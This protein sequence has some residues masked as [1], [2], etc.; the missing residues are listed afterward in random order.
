M[1]YRVALVVPEALM[2]L[3]GQSKLRELAVL[4]LVS[5]GHFWSHFFI[6][7]IPSAL[8]LVRAELH[9]S[10]VSIGMV[11]AASALM[12]A[13]W[14]FP[15]GV[16]SDRYGARVFLI[17]GLAAESAAVFSQSFAPTVPAMIGIALIGGI[18]DSVFHPADYTI[19]TA[20]VRLCW[21][22]RAYAVHTFSGFLGFAAAP[23]LMTYLIAHGGW[24]HALSVVGLAG[25]ATA[26]LLF[27]SSRL[28]AGDTYSPAR[29]AGS[30]NNKSLARFLLSP[31][32]LTMFVFYIVASLG[33]NGLQMFSNSAL[34]ELYHIDLARANS[35][36]AG[37]L[38]GTVIG[39]LVGGVVADKTRRLDAVVTVC[40]I[41]AAALLC[42]IGMATLSYGATIGAVFFTGLMLGAVMPS[43]D[44]M[45]RTM[46]PPGSIGKAFGYVSSGFGVAGVIGPL[47]YGAMLDLE[48]PQAVFFVA[49]S[50][51]LATIAVAILASNISARA[52]TAEG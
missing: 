31:P 13:G 17:C 45:V 40:Y 46:T 36:L 9:V 15:M 41:L 1:E 49:A 51:M 42:A 7:A 30:A 19:L 25:F 35:A 2:S 29:T 33:S 12:G 26:I 6:L 34:I 44:L 10:N 39:V 23:T 21:L 32:L 5:G 38:W 43:R 16:L 27:A 28:L 18:A 24:R 22:G 8:P 50:M 4:G 11:M 48:M 52:Q 20:N 37:F 3:G 14:Q 47:V